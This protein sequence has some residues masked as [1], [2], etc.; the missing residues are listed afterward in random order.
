MIVDISSDFT[1]EEEKGTLSFYRL[2]KSIIRHAL[3]HTK[4]TI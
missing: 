3:Y 2:H 4:Y 1:T